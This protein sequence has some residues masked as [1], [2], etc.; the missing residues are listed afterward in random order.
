MNVGK[1]TIRKQRAM[2]PKARLVRLIVLF[3]AQ[4]MYFPINRIVQGGVVLTVPWDDY[5]SLRPVWVLPYLLSL[6][7]WISCF[8]WAAWKMEGDFYRAFVIS[9]VSVML[10]SYVVYVVYPTYIVRPPLESNGLW[11]RILAHL[12]ANDRVNNAFPSGHTYNTVMI[13]LYWSRWHPRQRWLWFTITIIVLLSTLYTRQHNLPDLLG[14]IVFAWLGYCF[15][16]WWVTRR[17]KEA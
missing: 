9:L 7:W 16:L 4:F 17:P 15:G 5:F 6:V 1:Q 3:T 2:T 12:Y 11:T 8:I 14:G 13:A 10:V